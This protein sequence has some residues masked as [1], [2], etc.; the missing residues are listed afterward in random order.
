MWNSHWQPPRWAFLPAWQLAGTLEI[1]EGKALES[2][3]NHFPTPCV[4]QTL[5]LKLPCAG[6]GGDGEEEM[7]QSIIIRFIHLLIC[8]KEPMVH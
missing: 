7:V 8:F 6:L 5:T 4:C 1:L 2:E 3:G